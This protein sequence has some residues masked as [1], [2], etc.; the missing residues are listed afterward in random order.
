MHDIHLAVIGGTGVYGLAEL[1]DVEAHL[2]DTRYGLPSG[3]VRIGT[4]AGRRIASITAPTL[5]HCSRW[6]RVVCSR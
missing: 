5:R 3:P 4:L 1:A 6:E 2:P